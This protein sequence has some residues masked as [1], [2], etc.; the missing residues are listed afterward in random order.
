MSSSTGTR[1]QRDV[2]SRANEALIEA[3]KAFIASLK[4]FG[5]A[6]PTA[7][8][9]GGSINN[10]PNTPTGN[11]LA[12]EGD[13]MIG[14]FAL[15]PPVDFTVEV[16][17]NNTIDI[18][19]LNDNPQYSSNIQLDDLQ[20][21]SSVLDVIANA[22]FD[23]QELVIRTFAPTLPYTISQ[24][25]LGNGG[26]IQTGDSNDLIVG[27]LQTITL[28]FD[29]SLVVH[30]NTGGTWRVESTSAV[31]TGANG[32]TIQDEGIGLPQQPILNFVGPGVVVTN[33]GPGT[34]S[35]VTIAGGAGTIPNGTA[36]NDHLEWDNTGGVWLA[37]QAFTFGSTG[38]F[39]DSG[40][41]RFANDEIMLSARN[42]ADDG[43][44]ELKV[45]SADFFDFT[46][47]NNGIVGIKLRAQHATNP[48][49]TLT[50]TQFSGLTGQAELFSP[51]RF[52]FF[53][54]GTEEVFNFDEN[55]IET[56]K[57]ILPNINGTINLGGTALRYLA[58][59]AATFEF[60]TNRRLDFNTGGGGI[61][62]DGI[63]DSFTISVDSVTKA[64]MSGTLTT[65]AGNVN[66][67]GIAGVG[68]KA[69]FTEITAPVG[70]P[71]A[72]TG[73]AYA[74]EAN[75]T[76]SEPFWEDELGVVTNML[77]SR[78]AEFPAST[79]VD[80]TTGGFDILGGGAGQG[81]TNIGHLDFI[82]NLATPAAAV[83]LYSDGSDLFAN[84]GGG[85]VNLSDIA[86]IFSGLLSDLTIDANKDWATMSITNLASL[87]YVDSGSVPRG[88]IS[89]DAG[90]AAL[91]LA[92][93]SGGKFIIS[94]VITDIA[95]FT[96]ATGL[97]ML[98]THVINMG[99]NAINT[100][101]ET[102]FD[103]TT[104][105]SPTVATTIGFDTALN[106]LKYNVG[107]ITD[108]HAWYAAGE[109]LGS[110]SR[111]GA[112]SGQLNIDA[113]V[114]NILQA[115][116]QL[117]FTDAAT[118]P[119]VNGQFRRNGDDVLVF[120]GGAL[121]NLSDVGTVTGL[122][123]SR[124]LISDVS[125]NLIVSAITS[126]ELANALTGYPVGASVQTRLDALE[127]AT[128]ALDDLSDV[129][130]T[131]PTNGNVLT[132]NGSAWINAAGTSSSFAG[133][134]DTDIVTPSAGQLPI[135]D[136]VDTW[137]NTTVSGDITLNAA[138]V[139]TIPNDTVTYAKMQNVSATSRFLGRI[140]A[141]AGNTEE[142]TGTQATTL[143]N[144]FTTSLQGV[145]PGS[146]GGTTNF[147][148]AD[149][150]W[151]APPGGAVGANT[152][153]SNLITTA[154]NQSLLPV[155]TGT[156]HL[157]GASNIWDD[158][159][160]EEVL[161]FPGAAVGNRE[162]IMT[163]AGGMKYLTE[164]GNTH[165]FYINGDAFFR[166]DEDV[167]E[168]LQS[169]RQHAI[170]AQA[171]SI[172]IVSENLGDSVELWTG[173]SRTNPTIDVNDTTTTWRTETIDSA[174]M[175]LQIIQNNNTPADGRTLGNI[176][177]MAENSASSDEVY[178]RI[179]V[180]SQDI[181]SGTEDGLVQLGVVSD[182]T[183]VSGIDI[184]GGTSDAN[185]ALIGFFG[186]TPVARQTI[187]VGASLIQVVTALR[188]LNLGN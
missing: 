47:S 48:D 114:A 167:I 74:K 28:R 94:D 49:N 120:S 22:A 37:S 55:R 130:L 70:N 111:I 165:D 80:L 65:L 186:G 13:S 61:T 108:V 119:T 163:D 141:G 34:A 25:T 72:N 129:I 128:I 76:H 93:A 27:D 157:G 79:D 124:V 24:A 62:V 1:K 159:F 12:R 188:N 91:R 86:N 175:V 75:G 78:W 95:E 53:G 26:N 178:G 150:T 10:S 18:G 30:A 35:V 39:A 51:N 135:Y 89:G 142:L 104:A 174:A 151:A 170:N 6:N 19:P 41:N 143:L 133:L 92:T 160:V 23:G 87:Q 97:T 183:L 184:E 152:A 9:A 38:P 67:L 171:T 149:G 36:E 81:M 100:I 127:T 52:H 168:F 73:W 33:D 71:A 54:S 96:D 4:K 69:E 66:I 50:L 113:I 29:E 99:K 107:L 161:F 5:E 126:A 57:N 15:G 140:T 118:D 125:G 43:N 42:S 21:N 90:A 145:A 11:Y 45:D 85:V 112:S 8:S 136:G 58:V 173:A 16:D 106:F 84:T 172:Q 177:F 98:G 122:T 147:L 109:L 7:G 115:D 64:T 101:G 156:L 123:A 59:F 116:D 44:L 117:F 162:A 169:G 20:P 60:D 134:T 185:G 3:D 146:G 144:I 139:A 2:Q 181:T 46:E 138:G 176:D 158:A 131:T 83:S 180:S 17:A 105:F 40:F 31:V 164:N 14:P 102:Q 154:I 182:G 68:D 88:T 166:I 103:T 187:P 63:G 179:S 110:I 121:R 32:H 132:F 153:L 148:R 77:P 82:D 155:P 137:D 56:L